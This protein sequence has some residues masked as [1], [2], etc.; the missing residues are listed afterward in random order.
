VVEHDRCGAGQKNFSGWKREPGP[1][2]VTCRGGFCE[3]DIVGSNAIGDKI[4]VNVLLTIERTG[5]A[6]DM[7]RNDNQRHSG[8]MEQ[9]KAPDGYCVHSFLPGLYSG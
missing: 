6:G 1:G 3:G 2:R 8:Y 9:S 4:W 7:S 5:R